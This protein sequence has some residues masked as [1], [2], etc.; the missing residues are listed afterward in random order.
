MGSVPVNLL[1]WLHI[2]EL[3][4]GRF[5]LATKLFQLCFLAKRSRALALARNFLKFIKS[6]CDFDFRIM[7]RAL[8]RAEMVNWSSGDHQ[9]KMFIGLGRRFR[10]ALVGCIKDELSEGGSIMLN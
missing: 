7:C 1:I 2:E 4:T 9:G 3:E 5:I 6:F 8:L 10:D